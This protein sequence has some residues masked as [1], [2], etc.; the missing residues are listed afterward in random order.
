MTLDNENNPEL[1]CTLINLVGVPFAVLTI[2]GNSACNSCMQVYPQTLTKHSSWA[3]K[4]VKSNRSCSPHTWHLASVQSYM[5]TEFASQLYLCIINVLENTMVFQFLG[6]HALCWIIYNNLLPCLIHKLVIS[7]QIVNF[8]ST[9]LSKNS[10][11]SRKILY[12][13]I[14]ASQTIFLTRRCLEWTHN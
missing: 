13:C 14:Y 12:F 8:Y 1:L 9:K 6:K 5:I 10:S 4:C 11:L 3:I 7:Y 2:N